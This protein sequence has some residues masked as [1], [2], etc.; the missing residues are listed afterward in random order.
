MFVNHQASKSILFPPH[1]YI[2][3][4][5]ICN[6]VEVSNT[7]LK[8][9]FLRSSW[10]KKENHL[11]LESID[12]PSKLFWIQAAP[13]L[14]PWRTLCLKHFHATCNSRSTS[15]CIYLLFQMEEAINPYL[16]FKVIS[17]SREWWSWSGFSL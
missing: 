4:M 3:K 10:K 12:F 8:Q 7:F 15:W 6:E 1:K 16:T 5:T 17:F 11:D 13:C 14:A 9:V 2:L